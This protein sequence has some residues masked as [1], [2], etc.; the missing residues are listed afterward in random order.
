MWRHRHQSD[1]MQL[2]GPSGFNVREDL[3]RELSSEALMSQAMKQWENYRPGE[4]R[5][6]LS[7]DQSPFL[8]SVSDLGQVTLTPVLEC[9][10]LIWVPPPTMSCGVDQKISCW[11]F[12]VTA[13]V[14]DKSQGL[15]GHTSPPDPVLGL[16]QL[17][18]PPLSVV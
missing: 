12:T 5:I 15:F 14:H 3:S 4:E 1:G 7:V 2:I 11:S 6:S 16:R 18:W 9:F 8:G 13:D 10:L 17:S